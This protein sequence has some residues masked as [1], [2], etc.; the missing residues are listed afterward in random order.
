MS[1]LTPLPCTVID[2]SPGGLDLSVSQGVQVLRTPGRKGFATACNLGLK[3]A[4]RAGF[5]WVLLLND[6]AVP[7]RGCVDALRE[8]LLEDPTI[9]AAGPVL[10]R[11]NGQVESAGISFSTRSGRVSVLRS[12]PPC[13][14]EVDAI[15]GACLAL[16]SSVRF[17]GR[18]Q[19]YFEDVDLCIRLKKAGRRVVLVPQARCV[20][21]GGATVNRN[22]P[23]STR[24]A[25]QGHCRL[26]SH[27][28]LGRYVA[29]GLALGQVLREGGRG[30]R[31]SALWDGWR[32]AQNQ[33]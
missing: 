30:N 7:L 17:D 8:S 31:L 27:G 28:R 26:L 25:I 2:D 14:S 3:W 20:H 15:S 24:L 32:E 33:R 19:F 13:T 1:M 23:L 16:D 11:P 6:D 12:V 18:Y 5:K 4:R 22:S 10:F 21:L 29:L 9:A